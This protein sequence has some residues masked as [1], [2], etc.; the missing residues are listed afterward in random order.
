MTCRK[1]G[2]LAPD[3][4][5]TLS[6]DSS[7]PDDP[8]LMYSSV[9]SGLPRRYHVC[10]DNAQDHERHVATVLGVLNRNNIHLEPSKCSWHATGVDFL[11]FTVTA[12]KGSE[13]RDMPVPSTAAE[14]RFP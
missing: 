9:R 12:G 7:D 8:S 2:A 11:G 1:E 4:A 5:C 13:F 3:A 14:T 10:S 6:S